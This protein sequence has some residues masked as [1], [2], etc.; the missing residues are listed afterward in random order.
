MTSSRDFITH[1]QDNSSRR[2]V[3]QASGASHNEYFVDL[4]FEAE[5]C[6]I[7]KAA[8]HL[9]EL[10]HQILEVWLSS[11]NSGVSSLGKSAVQTNSVVINL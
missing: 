3:T 11:I 5:P 4:L 9:M 10:V 6:F 2:G 7:S 1:L 8:F